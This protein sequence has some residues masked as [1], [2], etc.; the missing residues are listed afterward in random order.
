MLTIILVHSE[1]SET[2]HARNSVQK[3]IFVFSKYHVMSFLCH[4]TE[5][6][7]LSHFVLEVC[8]TIAICVDRNRIFVHQ[9]IGLLEGIHY[10]TANGAL[11][12]RPDKTCNQFP[13]HFFTISQWNHSKWFTC[14]SNHSSGH[15]LTLKQ[16]MN[17]PFIPDSCPF[18]LPSDCNLCTHCLS[19]R[20]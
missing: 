3:V 1:G 11:F 18:L 14:Y 10:S 8:R 16:T 17:R 20:N 4:H 6:F 19:C 13:I 12:P 15:A 9:C 5:N 7:C 2:N